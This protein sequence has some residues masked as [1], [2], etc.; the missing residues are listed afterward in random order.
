MIRGFKMADK[1]R[2]L[3]VRGDTILSREAGSFEIIAI[4]QQ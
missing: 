4:F 1:E 3:P 2:D